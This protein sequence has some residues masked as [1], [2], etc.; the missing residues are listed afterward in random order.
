LGTYFK[1]PSTSHSDSSDAAVNAALRGQERKAFK[2]LCSNGVAKINPAT[3]LALQKLH[4]E[5]KS[6][7]VLPSTN[8]AQLSIDR[9]YVT[10][11]LFRESADHNLSKDVLWMGPV[12]IFQL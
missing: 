1:S 8:L 3:V 12:A 5:R 7:L 6:D 11:K 4:P 10:K 2:L 9:E